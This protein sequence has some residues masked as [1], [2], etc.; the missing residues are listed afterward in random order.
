MSTETDAGAVASPAEVR[1]VASLGGVSL[2][3][4]VPIEDIGDYLKDADNLVWMD[5]QDPGAAE[6]SMLLDEFG[7]H[8]LAL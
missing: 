7:F 1:T 6:L 4:N 3:R 2:E 5:V 8:P